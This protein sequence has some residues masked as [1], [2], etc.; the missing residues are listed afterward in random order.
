MS[1]YI[2]NVNTYLNET[3]IKKSYVSLMTE[4]DPSKLTRLLSKSQEIVATDMEKIATALGKN[5]EFFMAEDFENLIKKERMKT[6][7]AFYAGNPGEEQ[8]RFA[9]KLIELV[10]NIDHILGARGRYT[11][12]IG[13]E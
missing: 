12:S 3:K 11:M 1:K 8:E 9:S 13:E 6:E 7:V 10:D 2:D 4:I 5:V